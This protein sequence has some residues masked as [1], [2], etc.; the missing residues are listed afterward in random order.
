MTDTTAQ[1]PAPQVSIL[2]HFTRDLSFENVGVMK[3]IPITDK[4]EVNVTVNIEGQSL[5]EDRYQIALK[6][7]A[8]AK[9]GDQTRFAVELDYGGVFQFKNVPQEHVHPMLFI[10]CPR[11]L[12]P[13]ARRVISDVTRDGGYPPLMVDNIDFAALYRQRIEQLRAQQGDGAAAE[14]A[15]VPPAGDTPVN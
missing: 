7:N 3:G 2:A 1:Q 13:F 9:N 5:G 11:Q 8:S 15:A 12:I 10:E 4:P 14:P 6:F